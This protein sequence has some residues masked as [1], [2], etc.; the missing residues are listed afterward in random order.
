MTR[1]SEAISTTLKDSNFDR[2]HLIPFSVFFNNGPSNKNL[3][4]NKLYVPATKMGP[5]VTL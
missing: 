2:L 1:C 4:T 5:D 3:D